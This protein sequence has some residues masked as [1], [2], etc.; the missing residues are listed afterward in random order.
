MTK[1]VR[2]QMAQVKRKIDKIQTAQ[3]KLN[4]Y[5]HA[6][7]GNLNSTLLMKHAQNYFSGETRKTL[8]E[9]REGAG[10][11]GDTDIPLPLEHHGKIAE[12]LKTVCEAVESKLKGTCTPLI[13]IF[14]NS[15]K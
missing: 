5:Q 9:E 3:F 1:D 7:K 13:I 15:D 14:N 2:K 10:A 12:Q 8:L 11:G 6:Q 4:N